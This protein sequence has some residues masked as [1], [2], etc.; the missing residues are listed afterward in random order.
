MALTYFHPIAYAEPADA[1]VFIT[2]PMHIA[3]SIGEFFD[4]AANISS[5]E[6]LRN[7][8]FSIAY[9]SSLLDVTQ[10]IEGS[11]FP[12]P[13]RS[14]FRYEENET[15]G[16]IN[17]NMSLGGSESSVR[18]NGVLAWITFK[19]IREP[20]SGASS[21]LDFK[22]I[23]L[24]NSQLAPVMYDSVGALYFWKSIQP[25]PPTGAALDIYTQKGGVGPN[26]PG[27]EF[28]VDEIVNL[29]A[30]VTY[31]D[32]PVQQ[33][34]VAFEILNPLN[35]TVAVITAVSN[36]VGLAKTGFRIPAILSSDGTW[37]IVATV[38]V[39]GKKVWD[40]VQL[41]VRLTVPMGGYSFPLEVHT[42]IESLALYFVATAFL[43]TF[44][45]TIKRKT[46]RKV[47]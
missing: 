2:P 30:R 43:T 21:S 27:G 24:L 39:A 26:Q 22:Q 46:H 20:E 42:Q 44:F 4:I 34:L 3:R 38:D 9:N 6:Y 8:E 16:M 41:H 1:Y 18:G 19:V 45:V 23:L 7:V 36:D 14:Y 13:P 15:L 35:E 10:V 11:F 32:E 37:T 33:K 17:V 5:L 47:K 31:N 25:D 40:T 29:T 28:I 12:F